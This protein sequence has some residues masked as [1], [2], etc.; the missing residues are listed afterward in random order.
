MHKIDQSTCF[1]IQF[2]SKNILISISIFIMIITPFFKRSV[3]NC[4]PFSGGVICR[5][6]II[7]EFFYIHTLGGHREFHGQLGEGK[8]CPGNVGLAVVKE[9]RKTTGLGKP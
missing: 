9:I 3:Y 2:Y 8:I 1:W 4:S 7:S 6:I 5:F